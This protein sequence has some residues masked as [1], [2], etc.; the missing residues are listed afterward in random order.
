MYSTCQLYVICQFKHD[1][2]HAHW[3]EITSSFLPPMNGWPEKTNCKV[4]W[5]LVKIHLSTFRVIGAHS[6]PVYTRLHVHFNSVCVFIHALLLH[7]HPII[8]CRLTGGKW[9][10]A[11]SRDTHTLRISTFRDGTCLLWTPS[12]KSLLQGLEQVLYSHRVGLFFSMVVFTRIFPARTFFI[13]KTQSGICFDSSLRFT[14]SVC[15]S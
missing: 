3:E 8:F 9:H 6:F 7:T 13:P 15:S 10:M 2:K 12:S 1:R 5:K 11:F 14:P 4:L